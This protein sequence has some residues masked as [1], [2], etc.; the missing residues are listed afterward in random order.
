M[1]Y[2]LSLYLSTNRKMESKINGESMQ[3]YAFIFL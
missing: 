1:N 3:Y 2:E